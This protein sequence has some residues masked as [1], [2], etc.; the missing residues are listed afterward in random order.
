MIPKIDQ[1]SRVIGA[2]ISST[3][4]ITPISLRVDPA[5]DWLLMEA[6]GE[7]ITPT[8]ATQTKIDQNGHNTLYGV[9]DVD[10]VTLVPIRTNAAGELLIMI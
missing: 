5:T 1:N 3:D 8:T 6:I 4:S 7:V 2:G 9:S 10:G